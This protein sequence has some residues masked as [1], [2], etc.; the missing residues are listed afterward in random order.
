MTENHDAIVADPKT[1]GSAGGCPVAHDRA[2]H[3]TQGG[4][5]RQWWLERLN[6]KILVLVRE[7]SVTL[8]RLSVAR[9]I[10]MAANKSG[11]AKTMAQALA[12]GG[13]V[14]PFKHLPDGWH[15]PGLVVWW[16]SAALMTMAVVLT[17]TSGLEFVRDVAR[18]VRR[19]DG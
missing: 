1:E 11:K 5:N 6:V 12:L 10:V 17:V 9:R 19:H 2:L 15:T 7:W 4:G 16:I 18:Q 8:A 3:P 13:F 14:A